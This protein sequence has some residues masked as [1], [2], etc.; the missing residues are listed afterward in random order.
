MVPEGCHS[1]NQVGLG[2]ID[3]L[4]QQRSISIHGSRGL[5]LEG[6]ALA[7]G[8]DNALVQDRHRFLPGRQ[9]AIHSGIRG[10]QPA[11]Q[12]RLQRQS[13]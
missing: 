9:L 7:V 5:R 2:S 4:A 10:L 8:S 12:V 11:A 13:L 3:G 6:G 1:T